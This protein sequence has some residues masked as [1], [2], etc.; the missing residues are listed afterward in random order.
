M[1]RFRAT[2]SS[3]PS[4]SNAWPGTAY[5]A[6]DYR[7]AQKVLDFFKTAYNRIGADGSGGAQCGENV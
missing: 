7:N 4:A 1:P 2:G 3:S 6:S 5:Q